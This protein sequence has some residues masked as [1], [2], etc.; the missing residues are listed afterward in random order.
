M[1]GCFAL[2]LVLLAVAASA[3]ER[4]T[5][6][7]FEA[8][9]LPFAETDDV[10]LSRVAAAGDAPAD[11]P[12]GSALLAKTAGKARFIMRPGGVDELLS[13]SAIE[14]WIHRDEEAAKRGPT[15]IELQFLERDGRA[16]FWSKVRLDHAGWKKQALPLRW[17][18]WSDGRVPDWKQVDRWG[19]YFRDAAELQIDNV[20]LV[21]EDASD[22]ALPSADD[23]ARL[24]F[25]DR[26]KTQRA[27][28][29]KQGL[30]V[31]SDAPLLEVDRLAAHLAKVKG[32]LEV[33]LG[34]PEPLAWPATLIICATRAEYEAFFP[35]LAQQYQ[36]EISPPR[37]GGFTALGVAASYWDEEQGTLRPVFTHE[38]V[39]SLLSRDYALPNSGD[40][41]QEGLATLSQL[42]CH[43]QASLP[44]IVR[45]GIADPQ[46]H[47]PL[48]T[49]T[50]GERIAMTR[51][52]QAATLCELLVT[53]EKYRASMPAIMK[54]IRAGGDTKL[55]LYREKMLGVSWEELTADW[56]THCAAKYGED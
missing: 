44:K 19:V 14:L 36:A 46:S 23:Y 51:Y 29:D 11:G 32:E 24:A 53:N 38:F 55:A 22:S 4:E 42:R 2:T 40:W 21:R 45:D 25:G 27:I 12:Q 50:N 30:T 10:E 41:L 17:F 5:L 54:A 18:R 43:P 48:E 3:E 9:T 1:R 49:L 16:R 8:K 26:K 13:A 52:W 37:S 47:E 28:D 6:S 7:D 15:T 20:V 35:R 33:E 56:K 34:K 31:L 39:H